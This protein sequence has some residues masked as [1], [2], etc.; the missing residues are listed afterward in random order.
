MMDDRYSPGHPE[1][2]QGMP[3]ARYAYY[4][5]CQVFKKYGEQCKA[6]AEKGAHICYAHAREQAA[7]FRRKLQLTILLAGV[8]RR[9]RQRGMPEFEAADIFMDFNAIQVTLG[10][11]AQAVIDG[12]IDCKTAGRLLI[13]LQTAAK[14]LRMIH[15]QG[16]EVRE[17]QQIRPQICADESRSGKGLTT[18]NPTPNGD[19][20]GDE[21]SQVV[22]R[23]KHIIEEREIVRIIPLRTVALHEETAHAPPAQARAA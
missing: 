16:R 23:N 3:E 5:R 2:N 22:P 21:L 18:K 17:G 10:V 11:V 20:G 15:R 6:P 7:A 4:R 12:R 19:M 9:M 1:E 13:G 14:V 8:V